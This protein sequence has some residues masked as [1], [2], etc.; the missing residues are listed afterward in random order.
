MALPP[1]C[2][3]R[4]GPRS[5]L[6]LKKFI[7]LGASVIDSDYRGEL[8]VVLFNFANEDFIVNMGD[9]IA[10][11][12]F[13]E[14]KTL[15]IKETDSLEEPGWGSKGYGSTGINAE[16]SEQIQDINT[17]ISDTNQSSSSR[18]EKKRP[19]MNEPAPQQAQLS[20]KRQIVSVHQIQ[21]L[22]N[23]NNHVFLPI[24]R[25]TKEAP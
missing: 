14:I 23:G 17:K 13:E 22:G 24:V 6:A 8:G 3:G 5:G 11:L 15:E 9:K 1:G 18:P 10:Q 4:I 20:Q 16:W 12:I 21:K 2:Y 25:Q 7:D 19:P